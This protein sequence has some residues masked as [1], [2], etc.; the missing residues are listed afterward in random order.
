MQLIRGGT[1]SV[2]NE[3]KFVHQIYVES[4][5]FNYES[6]EQP[7]GTNVDVAFPKPGVFEV[8]CHIHPKMLLH[9]EVQ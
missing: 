5:A 4:P 6:D 7:P 1:L 2:D 3:D 9:V 8:R